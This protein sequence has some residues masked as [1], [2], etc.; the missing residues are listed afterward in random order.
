MFGV[1]GAFARIEAWSQLINS[2]TGIIVPGTYVPVK[3]KKELD[4]EAG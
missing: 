4:T 3:N 2:N 1:S